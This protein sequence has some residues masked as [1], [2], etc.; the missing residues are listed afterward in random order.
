[1][2]Y[3]VKKSMVEL[4][5]TKG[6][7]S[8]TLN[9]TDKIN[10]APSVRLVQN[11]ALGSVPTDTILPF[12]GEE[13]P[14]GYEEVSDLDIEIE[15]DTALNSESQNPVSNAAITTELNKKI[16]SSN[17]TVLNIVSLTNA[18]FTSLQSAGSLVN[19]TIYNIID[20]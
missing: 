16:Q 10:N 6:A 13:I 15:V 11:L 20:D 19:G 14:E 4:E 2:Q 7:I 9:V 8:D 17:S 18:E 1:M 5:P 12:D 3:L